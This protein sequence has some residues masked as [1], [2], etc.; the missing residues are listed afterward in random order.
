[1][2]GFRESIQDVR[3]GEVM[4]FY[5]AVG[6]AVTLERDVTEAAV[7][8]FAE[9][10]GDYSPNHVDQAG[11]LDSLYRGRIAHG[12]LLVAYMSACSTAIV[13]RIPNARATETPVSLG[14]D[15]IRFLKPVY[16]GDHLTLRYAI[17]E[18]DPTRRRSRSDIT[19]SN[20]EAE[21]VC[22]GEHILK[23]VSKIAMHRGTKPSSMIP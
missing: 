23:W 8:A 4:D 14:Y 22:V 15:R 16:I 7:R 20:Q 6:D 1:M 2:S 3:E 13:E 5:L 9:L 12:A 10:S 17:R 11:M 21:L 19:I 18:I